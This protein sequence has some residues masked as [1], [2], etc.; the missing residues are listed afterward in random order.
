MLGFYSPGK[1]TI[2]RDLSPF[3]LLLSDLDYV[4]LILWFAALWSQ[5]G[6]LIF[7][8]LT[9]FQARGQKVQEA[10]ASWISFL[11]ELSEK[12]IRDFDLYLMGHNCEKCCP[13]WGESG[14]I[15][16]LAK[17]IATS[18]KAGVLFLKQR[19]LLLQLAF[20]LSI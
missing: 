1:P 5:N 12:I 7:S 3:F 2:L 16:F 11:Q 9:T 10:S 13:S 6:C 17:P 15:V 14:I 18:N 19:R 20:S 4:A 8:I